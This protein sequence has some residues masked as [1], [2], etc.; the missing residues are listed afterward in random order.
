[1]QW[2]GTGQPANQVVGQIPDGAVVPKNS[3]VLI[4]VSN[5]K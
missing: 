5:G 4:F 1:V 3:S 2:T